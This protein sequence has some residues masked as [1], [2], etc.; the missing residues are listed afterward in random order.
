MHIYTD[1]SRNGD[2]EREGAGVNIEM[3]KGEELQ[4]LSFP[5]GK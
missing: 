3:E 5:A 1:G 2:Q 4:R